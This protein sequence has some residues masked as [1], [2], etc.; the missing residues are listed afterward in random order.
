MGAI[1][2]VLVIGGVGAAV[3]V[4]LSTIY[5]M[6]SVYDTDLE[7]LR[8]QLQYGQREAD[9]N[10]Q[11]DAQ[12]KQRVEKMRLAANARLE[13]QQLHYVQCVEK[14]RLAANARIEQRQLVHMRLMRQRFAAFLDEVL[15]PVQHLPEVRARICEFRQQHPLV[16]PSNGMVCALP[17]ASATPEQVS[18]SDRAKANPV[19]ARQPSVVVAA[20]LPTASAV[21]VQVIGSHCAADGHGVN[22]RPQRRKRGSRGCQQAGVQWRRPQRDSRGKVTRGCR[23]GR[24]KQRCLSK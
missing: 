11:W 7:R 3:A 17:V 9:A 12:C 6:V 8:L 1:L 18:N 5:G 14:M 24:S 23:G 22:T 10:A 16:Q 19:T 2:V 15:T 4:S 13:Q 20:V 21:P